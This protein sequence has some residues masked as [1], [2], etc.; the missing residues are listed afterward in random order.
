VTPPSAAGRPLP[1]PSWLTRPFW[2]ACA[3]RR[4]VRP[5]CDACNRS[6]FTPQLCCPHCLSEAWSWVESSGR[7]VVRT[8]CVVHRPPGPGFDPPYVVADVDVEEG[9]HL[10][11]NIVGCDPSVVAAGMPVRVGWLALEAEVVLPVF[12]PIFQDAT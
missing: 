1:Q 3:D 5:V 10:M 6:F 11:T 9:W 2:D 12:T 8:S 7:G 4:L